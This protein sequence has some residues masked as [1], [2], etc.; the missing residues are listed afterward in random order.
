MMMTLDEDGEWVCV[1]FQKKTFVVIIV[2]L[3]MTTMDAECWAE[4]K[5]MYVYI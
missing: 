1:F 2:I 5:S 3:V 4:G